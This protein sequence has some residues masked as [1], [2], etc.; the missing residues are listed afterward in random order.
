MTFSPSR[1]IFE[2]LAESARIKLEIGHA[3][4]GTIYDAVTAITQAFSDGNKLLICGNGGSA[5]DS[6]HLAAEFVSR[7]KMNR[8]GLGA[9]ALTTDTS[10]LTAHSNDFSFRDVFAR[11]VGALGLPG[12]ILIGFSTSGNSGNVL[13]AIS[14]AKKRGLKTIGFTGQIGF[15]SPQPDI[16]IKVPS[17]VTA[18]IQEAHIAVYH[19]ITDLV[20]KMLF[21]V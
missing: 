13:D 1:Y 21:E 6:Q 16:E 8:K 14:E 3:H 19:V 15:Q 4:V 7:Y 12:D 20:E 9:I 2:H 10:F 18:H 17:R 5:A 11:Q